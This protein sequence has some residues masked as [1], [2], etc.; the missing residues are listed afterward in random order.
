MLT[1]NSS[2]YAD[3]FQ[4]LSTGAG[5]V[6]HLTS[7]HLHMINININTN[8]TVVVS[9]FLLSSAVEIKRTSHHGSF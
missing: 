4:S 6:V 2:N 5:Y 9:S 3:L 1:Q 7:L 8:I